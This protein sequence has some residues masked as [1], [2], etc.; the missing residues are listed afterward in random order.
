ML[1]SC[2]SDMLNNE[3]RVRCRVIRKGLLILLL[4]SLIVLSVFDIVMQYFRKGN[5]FTGSLM[6]RLIV[7]ILHTTCQRLIQVVDHIC[8]ICY[9]Y[10]WAFLKSGFAL[11]FCQH[12]KMHISIFFKVFLILRVTSIFYTK[13]AFCEVGT[14]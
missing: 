9:W 12:Q 10:V 8:I 6:W 13:A 5:H 4:K 14:R 2:L 3:F 7:S 11:P 1:S